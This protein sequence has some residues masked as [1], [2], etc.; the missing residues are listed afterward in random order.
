MASRC[1]FGN[2]RQTEPGCWMV[3]CWFADDRDQI[4]KPFQLFLFRQ[5]PLALK[6]FRQEP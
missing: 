1:F 3:E 2:P 6:L 4:P 5:E